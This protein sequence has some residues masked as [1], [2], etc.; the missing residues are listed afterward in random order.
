VKRALL[1]AAV[2]VPLVLVLLAGL[3]LYEAQRA[4]LGF[5]PAVTTP[6]HR[7]LHPL[8]HFDEG[9]FNASTAGFGGRYLPFARLLRADGYDVRRSESRFSPGSLD[10]VAVLVVANA[11]GAAKPQ[12]LGINLPVERKGD[13]GDPAFTEEEIAV[14]RGWVEQ[15]G[16]LLLVA[17]HAPFGR[18]AAGLASAFGVTMYQGFTEVPAETSDPLV[19]S[20]ANARLGEHPVLEGVDTVMTFTGQS[21]D[22]PPGATVLL[23]LPRGAVEHVDSG[24]ELVARPAG[25][26][27]GLAFTFGKGRVV[28]LGEAAMITAQ[29]SRGVAFGMQAPPNDNQKLALG[30]LRWLSEPR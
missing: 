29:V 23:A 15:G 18:A 24:G 1:L 22:G 26:A 6:G 4:D 3:A 10:G 14:V 25:A 2:V 5:T 13:R 21:L 16:A 20:R 27:Q 11:S 12:F 8:V 7:E 28:V 9:H 19:F 30:I 17:D